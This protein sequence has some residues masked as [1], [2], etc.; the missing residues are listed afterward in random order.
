MPEAHVVQLDFVC[1]HQRVQKRL[2]FC[3]SWHQ[4]TNKGKK[5]TP[6]LQKRKGSH[7]AI[8]ICTVPSRW[9]L[10]LE[11]G[12]RDALLAGNHGILGSCVRGVPAGVCWLPSQPLESSNCHLSCSLHFGPLADGKC[13]RFRPFPLPFCSCFD[14]LRSTAI[15]SPMFS[16]V[17]NHVLAAKPIL[18]SK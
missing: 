8:T 5:L 3:S 4:D 12:L 7:A 13:P 16:D 15:P 1:S 14:A 18:S 10:L 6:Q 11:Q 9:D 17:C 2:W